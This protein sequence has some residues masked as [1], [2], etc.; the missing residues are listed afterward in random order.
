[1]KHELLDHQLVKVKAKPS[2]SKVQ[3]KYRCEVCGK[4]WVEK[5][6]SKCPGAPVYAWDPWPEGLFTR[7]QLAAKKLN[8]GPLAGVIPYDKSADGNGWLRLY[9]E[10]EATPKPALS[11][12][13]Q[14]ARTKKLLRIGVQR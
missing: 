5:P 2:K 1:M 6:T 14:A 8:P 10:S 12:K 4:G 9:R 13:H 3:I 11:P 7:K